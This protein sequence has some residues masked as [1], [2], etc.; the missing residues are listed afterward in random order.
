MAG[1]AVFRRLMHGFARE[2]LARVAAEAVA[3]GGPYP[4]MGLVAFVAVQPC[5]GHFFRKARF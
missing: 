3:I 2:D 5:H 4:G 1:C